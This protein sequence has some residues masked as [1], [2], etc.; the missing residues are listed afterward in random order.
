[1]STV[2]TTTAEVEWHQFDGRLGSLDHGMPNEPALLFKCYDGAID[3]AAR[4]WTYCIVEFAS[5]RYP[6]I[7][8]SHLGMLGIIRDEGGDIIALTVVNPTDR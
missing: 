6:S 4:I 1:M 2:K 5:R 8:V 3:K 7:M